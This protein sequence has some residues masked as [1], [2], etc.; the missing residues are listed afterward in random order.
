MS[1][2]RH[3]AHYRGR[4]GRVNHEPTHPVYL[5]VAR[6]LHGFLR[7]ITTAVWRGSE[8]LPTTGAAI[9]ASN[10]IS[11]LDPLLLGEYIIWNGRWPHFLAKATLF[12]N[13]ILL[14]ILKATR[15]IPVHRG[16][17]RAADALGEAQRVLE[18][19][20]VVII[21]PEGTIT[22][23]PLEWP[24]AAHSGAVRLSMATGAPIIPVG[25]WGA[26]FALPPWGTRLWQPKRHAVCLVAGPAV[27][28]GGFT[29]DREGVRRASAHLMAAI[30]CCVEQARGE[31]APA[32]RWHQRRKERV[33]PC[34]AHL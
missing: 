2:P 27:D 6:L 18:S 26:N 13:P 34:E 21:Y 17:A 23:D 5:G 19:G 9:I 3:Q 28:L 22:A 12:R 4:L 11:E 30:T 7:V 25:Q 14:P 16:T 29:N 32:T 24:M 8:H 10:H 20:G 15:Q 33:R 31:R 1:Y